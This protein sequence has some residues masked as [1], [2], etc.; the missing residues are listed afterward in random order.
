[1]RASVKGETSIPNIEEVRECA[2]VLHE[3]W[4][5]GR[6]PKRSTICVIQNS[7][8][9]YIQT[10]KSL[11]YRLEIKTS[12]YLER[13]HPMETFSD[14]DSGFVVS[15]IIV[16]HHALDIWCWWEKHIFIDLNPIICRRFGRHRTTARRNSVGFSE[17]K[18]DEHT[19][20]DRKR[21]LF[22]W[23]NDREI[24]T[25]GPHT[26]TELIVSVQ[27]RYNMS[28]FVNEHAVSWEQQHGVNP[29]CFRWEIIETEFE[30]VDYSDERWS[31]M[32]L[33]ALCSITIII[34]ER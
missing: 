26:R 2:I 7:F 28:F 18:Q 11:R 1:M 33:Q 34:C 10:N 14:L 23:K 32:N 5:Y 8:T 13:I 19:Q 29:L 17:I 12:C 16:G 20:R 24:E 4:R 6:L 9:S 15:F 30:F 3:K 25:N 21:T 27:K 22:A 31:Q